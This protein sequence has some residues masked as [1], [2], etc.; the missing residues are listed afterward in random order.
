MNPL[1]K[2]G[3]YVVAAL[4]LV[5]AIYFG[6]HY[7]EDIG[8]QEQ[9]TTDQ[10]ATETAKREA[11]NVLLQANAKVHQLEQEKQAIVDQQNLKDADHE[12]ITNNLRSQLGAS[13]RLR[14]PYALQT[15]C[16]SGSPGGS[17]QSSGS[18]DAG[19]AN[20]GKTGGLLSAELTGLLDRL[21][22]EADTINDAYASCRPLVLK[23]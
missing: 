17:V 10:L 12:K 16:G 2:L 18:A 3:L 9:L 19:P 7:L 6:I 8:R 11:A 4:M 1:I 20:G 5:A 22:S 21:L 23:P 13:K 14:D 15:G